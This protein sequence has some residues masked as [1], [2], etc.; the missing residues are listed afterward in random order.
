MQQLASRKTHFSTKIRTRIVD[1]AVGMW[2][3]YSDFVSGARPCKTCETKSKTQISLEKDLLISN[4]LS[5]RHQV[6]GRHLF[7]YRNVVLSDLTTLE[8]KR[9]W[10]SREREYVEQKVKVSII[11]NTTSI[12]NVHDCIG[13][14]LLLSSAPH[15]YCVSVRFYTRSLGNSHFYTM[16]LKNVGTYNLNIHMHFF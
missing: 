12:I 4:K 13:N 11:L 1:R 16:L 8:C 15:K 9:L 6:S 10:S 2:W 5:A 3:F 14:A 7:F